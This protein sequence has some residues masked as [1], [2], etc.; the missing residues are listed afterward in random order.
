VS[1]LRGIRSHALVSPFASPG[2]VDLSA[3][4]DFGGLVE[5]ALGASED[6]EAHGPV[7]QGYFLQ[8]LGGQERVE[9][10]MKAAKDEEAREV[11]RKAWERLVS[12]GPRGMGGIYKALAILPRIEGKE[13]RRPVGFGGG[14]V[15]N[16]K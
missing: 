13:G 4:V 16:S 5:T 2:L 15:E 3:D 9:M 6:V 12:L 8:A 10:L 7:P 1:T 14:V 11:V